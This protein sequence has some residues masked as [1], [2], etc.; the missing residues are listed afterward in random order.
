MDLSQ[1]KRPQIIN[2]DENTAIKYIV[3]EETINLERLRQ[4]K[5][6][7]TSQLNMPEPADEV[8]IDMGKRIHPFYQINRDQLQARIDQIDE[9]LNV[10]N[11]N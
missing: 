11:N 3:V 8:L 4:E 10:D 7:L 1:V 5:E 6:M 9:V 2:I